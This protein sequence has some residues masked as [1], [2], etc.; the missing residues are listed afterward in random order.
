MGNSKIT[1]LRANLVKSIKVVGEVASSSAKAG[2]DVLVDG[3]GAA[4]KSAGE[5][6]EVI[7]D[8]VREALD[9]AYEAKRKLAVKNLAQ[10]RKENPEASPAEALDLLEAELKKVE[11]IDGADSERFL[12]ATSTFVFSAVEL[13]PGSPDDSPNKQRLIDAI[14]L[15]DSSVAKN[16][17]K[18]GELALGILIARYA[19]LGKVAGE[20]LKAS[21][22]VAWASQLLE[23]A[24]IKNPGMK[25][26]AWAIDAA[27]RK[28]LGA[29][30]ETW[31][32]TRLTTP[33][34][35]SGEKKTPKKPAAK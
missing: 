2:R 31:P 22:K 3:V 17:A 12:S 29:V 11:S 10:L 1:D 15:L 35:P 30:P 27:T 18:Y 6:K 32:A 14:V 34:A 13:Y 9:K 25:G 19:G 16:I 4:S 5:A 26:T 28:I 33:S 8:K 24:G 20:I 21:A 7:D 23:L